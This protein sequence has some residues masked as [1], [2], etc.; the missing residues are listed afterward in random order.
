MYAAN[1]TGRAGTNGVPEK[2]SQKKRD[3]EIRVAPFLLFRILAFQP[4]PD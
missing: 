4:F 1:P 2:I 3:P